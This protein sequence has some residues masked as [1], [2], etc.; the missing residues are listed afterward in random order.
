M[1]YEYSKSIFTG[2]TLEVYRYERAP[3]V[4][5]GVRRRL[6]KETDS[7][8]DGPPVK[9]RW[10]NIRRLRRG[11]LRLVQS[12]LSANGAPSFATLTFAA[13][14][15]LDP[16]LLCFREFTKLLRQEL[17]ASVSYIAVP[18]F[19]KR[20]ATHFHVLFWGIGDDLVKNE[21]YS[22]YLQSI[23]ARGYLD[24]IPTDGSPKL[25][26]YMAKYMQKALHD[27][28]LLK[29]RAYYPSRNV[30]RPV[31][32][33]TAAIA[34]YAKEVLDARLELVSEK[35]YSTE[36]LGQGSYEVYNVIPIGTEDTLDSIL[37]EN[38]VPK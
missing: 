36:W 26:G 28:R 12:Q 4:A 35:V 30:V 33:K 13:N 8:G 21:R 1:I 29:R 18:E 17:G 3:K 34:N 31:L 15:P 20:G 5:T 16:A 37:E 9:R 6:P 24:I 19:Q 7:S 11:F 25:A 10:D 23:W 38:I 14:V 27:D 22:R 32:Y 2:Q